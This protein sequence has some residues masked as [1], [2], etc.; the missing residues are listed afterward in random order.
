MYPTHS[1][2]P[3]YGAMRVSTATFGQQRNRPA[4]N[5]DSSYGPKN[6]LLHPQPMPSTKK[7]QKAAAARAWAARYQRKTVDLE[8]VEIPSDSELDLAINQHNPDGTHN[9]DIEC[10]GWTGGVNYVPSD[11]DTDNEGW[12]ETDLDGEG[13]GSDEDNNRDL[14]DLEGEDLL[15]GLQ[16]KWELQQELE[17][18]AKPTP[19]KHVMKKTIAKEWKKAEAKQGL[20]YN[21]QSARRK[22]EV[23]QQLWEK[24]ERDKLMLSAGSD[25]AERSRSFFM[26]IPKVPTPLPVP[27]LLH[28]RLSQEPENLANTEY[29]DDVVNHNA[30]TICQGYLSDILSEGEDVDWADDEDDSPGLDTTSEPINHPL[31]TQNIIPPPQPKRRKLDIP[32][33]GANGLQSKRARLIQTCLHMVIN[34]KRHLINVLRNDSARDPKPLEEGQLEE[35]PFGDDQVWAVVLAQEEQCHM[36]VMQQRAKYHGMSPSMDSRDEEEVEWILQ[37]TQ[38]R[39]ERLSLEPDERHLPGE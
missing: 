22:R 5:L 36:E 4:K 18:L 21:G 7:A 20:G 26:V 37:D 28:V 3:P 12:K 29:E 13:V 11:T 39:M 27:L 24:E 19:Y 32:A 2:H 1:P 34:N 25:Q 35:E 14:E 31:S 30:N 33:P 8:V 9:L 10:T 15:D 6:T 16:N 17:D 23:A 38:A